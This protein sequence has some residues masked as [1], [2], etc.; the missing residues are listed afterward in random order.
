MCRTMLQ[1]KYE[2]DGLI[3]CIDAH[4]ILSICHYG[5]FKSIRKQI[6]DYIK[7]QQNGEILILLSSFQFFG[8]R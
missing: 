7:L 6:Y 1:S 4:F 5:K 8:L 3:L 2:I